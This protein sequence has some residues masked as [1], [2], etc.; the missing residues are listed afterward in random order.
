MN[1]I[2]TSQLTKY[3][4]KNRGIINVNLKITEGEVFGFI[5]PNG[6]GKSTTIRTLLNFIHPTSGIAKIFGM[7]CT[8]ESESIKKEIGYLPA[9]INYY[10]DMTVSDLLEYSSKFYE[11]DFDAR[12]K[13]LCNIFEVEKNKKI[14]ELSSGN[15]KKTAL[16][17]ALLH[18]PKLLI[19]DEPTNGLDPL[20]QQKFFEVLKNE[21]KNGTT[22]FFSSHILS[23][24]QK[25]CSKVAIIR[26][27]K[28]LKIETI[29]NLRASNYKKVT[30]EF[31]SAEMADEYKAEGM[32]SKKTRG[33]QAYF[34]YRGPVEKLVA[35]LYR[36]KIKNLNIQEPELEEIFMH[37]YAKEEE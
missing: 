10:D 1:I 11:G 8:K 26:E 34:L 35:S 28:I 37:Y 31:D 24:V 4:G 15:K 20:M 32:T 36:V 29:D 17:Q 27:G 18:R 16:V 25:M 30:V 7:D 14:E 6:A 5:G 3:Y 22:I 9:E 13:E 12:T 2:E 33:S 19:L 21:N 23:E